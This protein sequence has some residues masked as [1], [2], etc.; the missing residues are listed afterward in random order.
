MTD[1]AHKAAIQPSM[2]VATAFPIRP[3]Q[4]IEP[5]TKYVSP[6]G[7]YYMIQGSDGNLMVKM[8]MGDRYL[9]GLDRQGVT[10]SKVKLI[11]MAP[12]GNLIAI[13][14][15]GNVLW[16]PVGSDVA[17][18]SYL[19]LSQGNLSV[20]SPASA[21]TWSSA[22]PKAP[23]P[24][25]QKVDLPP[26]PSRCVPKA[27]FAKCRVIASPRITIH[28][29]ART[30][31]SAM[32][33]VEMIYTDMT[34]KLKPAFPKSK[35]NFVEIL[36]TNDESAAELAKLPGIGDNGRPAT[37]DA[38]NAWLLGGGGPNTTWITEQMMC[39]TGVKTRGARDTETRTY[40]QIVHEFAHTMSF[41]FDYLPT[42][43]R[44]FAGSVVPAEE[45]F[46]YAVQ[47]WFDPSQKYSVFRTPAFDAEI[48]KIFTSRGS[49]DC[50]NYKG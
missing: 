44:V 1:A 26:V 18:G 17:S 49:Y 35:L 24:S 14:A 8:V 15:E 21:I 10:P 43:N 39:K 37:G 28:G 12:D 4:T 22:E 34:S 7:I 32:D 23:I 29:T 20:I 2:D 42:I 11:R 33:F 46:P 19:T 36:I 16:S 47:A 38:S 45:A 3:G 50:A 9:W 41:R 27:G 6:D 5:G 25:G 13:D 48:A 31:D 30:T 40:D